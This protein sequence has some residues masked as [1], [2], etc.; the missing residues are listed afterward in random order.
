MNVLLSIKPEFAEKILTNEKQYE[1][2]KTGFRDV[3]A[4][5]NV[6][7]YASSP[8]KRIVG[9]FI[10]NS[11]VEMPPELLWRK[12]GT[13]SGIEDRQRF[14]EYFDG[15]EGGYAIEI[16]EAFQLKEP[17]NP[18]EYVDDFRPPVSFQY[19]NNTLERVLNAHLPESLRDQ[20]SARLL[21]D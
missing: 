12:F 20:R 10:M 14:M 6:F 2:R 19:V 5:K 16:D 21:E 11:V 3:S 18:R 8:V 13:G 17:I 15:T 4:I 7:M 1:F 9:V